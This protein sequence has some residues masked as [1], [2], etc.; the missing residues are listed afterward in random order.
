MET[1]SD[2]TSLSLYRNRINYIEQD[3][4]I[5]LP[6]LEEIYLG[7]NQLSVIQRATFGHLKNVQILDLHRNEIS[8]IESGSLAHMQCLRRLNLRRNNLQIVGH[9]VFSSPFP[10]N[11]QI[12]YRCCPP[13]LHVFTDKRN[14]I[15]MF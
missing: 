6:K 4:F 8:H 12:R 9:D 5:N 2:A 7:R 1:T 11:L 3:S 13:L 15:Y 10:N 14:L